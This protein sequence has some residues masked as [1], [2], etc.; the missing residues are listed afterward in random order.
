MRRRMSED[1]RTQFK[2]RVW[3]RFYA[4]PDDVW[5]LKTDP[6]HLQAEFRPYFYLHV[7]DSKGLV[8]AFAA[9]APGHFDGRLIPPGVSWPIELETVERP[10]RYADSSSNALF[11]MFQHDHRIQTTDDGCR[12]ID[13][14]IFSTSLPAQKLVAIMLQRLF[15]HRHRVAA[16]K[17]PT[18][19]KATA[20]SVLRVHF[21]PT[22]KLV[23][24]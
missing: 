16:R 13:E 4:P 1:N 20:V 23:D 5:R 12:Y 11:P 19:L 2:L 18:D 7:P 17:L 6:K 9:G 15:V 8:E 22:S 10:S 24:D 21:D 14:V 3:T